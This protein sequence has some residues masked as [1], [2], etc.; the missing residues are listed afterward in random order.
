MNKQP[1]QP[2]REPI[3]NIS[4]LCAMTKR[5]YKDRNN[6][7]NFDKKQ[8]FVNFI[9]LNEN[10]WRNGYFQQNID[11]YYRRFVNCYPNILAEQKKKKTMYALDLINTI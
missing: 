9:Y 11:E 3:I 8:S 7:D 2:A 4:E 10:F 5:Y 1:E 6:D